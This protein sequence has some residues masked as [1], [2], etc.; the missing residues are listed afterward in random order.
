[1]AFG[2]FDSQITRRGYVTEAMDTIW[3]ERSTVQSLSLIH[4]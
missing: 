1:M 3:S 4:I 2:A